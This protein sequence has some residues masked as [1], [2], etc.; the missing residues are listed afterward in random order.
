MRPQSR[1]EQHYY[2]HMDFCVG[3]MYISSQRLG[4]LLVLI[5]PILRLSSRPPN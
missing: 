4:A 3:Q 2:L 5:N 1:I